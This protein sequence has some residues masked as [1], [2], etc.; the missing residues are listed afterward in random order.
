MLALCHNL[1]AVDY[2]QS[3]SQA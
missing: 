3:L 1:K 2:T